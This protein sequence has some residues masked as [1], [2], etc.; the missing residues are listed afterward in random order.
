MDTYSVQLSLM[1]IGT[2]DSSQVALWVLPFVT[3][4]IKCIHKAH[5][6]LLSLTK[7]LY[8][9]KEQVYK[10]LLIYSE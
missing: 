6:K 4:S 9:C 10:T 1:S 5:L 2:A 3:Q 7:V 8:K